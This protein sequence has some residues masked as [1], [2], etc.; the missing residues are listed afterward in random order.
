MIMPVYAE[1]PFISPQHIYEAVRSP[2]SFLFESIKGPEK[3]ARYSFIG[4]EPFLTF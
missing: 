3:I 1:L 2:Y 4:S